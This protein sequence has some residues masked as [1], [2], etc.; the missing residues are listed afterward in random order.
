[1]DEKYEDKNINDQNIQE[2]P[3]DIDNLPRKWRYIHNHL[4]ELI[5]DVRLKV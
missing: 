1:M 4:K 5:I 3:Q 2:Q